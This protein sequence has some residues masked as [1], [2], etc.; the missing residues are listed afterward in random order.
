MHLST[1][2]LITDRHPHYPRSHIH[3]LLTLFSVFSPQSREQLKRAVDDCCAK[4]MTNECSCCMMRWV[5]H[6]NFFAG[7][8][9]FSG[10]FHV[11]TYIVPYVLNKNRIPRINALSDLFCLFVNLSSLFAHVQLTGMWTKRKMTTA[12]MT[13]LK[14]SGVMSNF[15]TTTIYEGNTPTGAAVTPSPRI[16]RVDRSSRFIITSTFLDRRSF[17]YMDM[18]IL[19]R[20][21]IVNSLQQQKIKV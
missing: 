19:L 4:L 17:K 15:I 16:R 1:F 2:T 6:D 12:S 10:V 18:S 7:L 21:R 3:T 14:N 11:R 20:I 9:R 5:N 13:N 8:S